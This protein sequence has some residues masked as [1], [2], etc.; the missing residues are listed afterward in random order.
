VIEA[1]CHCGAV[2]IELPRKPRRLTDCNCSVC[3]RYGTLW[4]YYP[5]SKVRIRAP[6]GSTESY[7]WGRRDLAF[8]RCRKC[9]CLMY[10]K[11]IRE[12]RID[13]MGVNARNLDPK[14]REGIRVR[15]LDG[16]A[17]W[18]WLD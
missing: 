18:K 15:R 14:I 7:S 16:A 8:V 10:W 11:A 13:R 9:G 17:T 5:R 3:R 12:R 2:K 6:R 4:A 1:I